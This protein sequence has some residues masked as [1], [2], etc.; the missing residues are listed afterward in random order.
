MKSV[1]SIVL[2]R[3]GQMEAYLKACSD[4]KSENLPENL[5]K[6]IM[7]KANNKNEAKQK[8]ENE[9]PGWSVDF[10]SIDRLGR[11]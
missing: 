3:D 5:S 10:D 8:A 2:V 4:I 11:C 9:H 6:S 1:Y 7:I